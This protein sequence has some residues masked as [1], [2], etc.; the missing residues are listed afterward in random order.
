RWCRQWPMSAS[1]ATNSNPWSPTTSGR[2]R[3]IA[4]CCSSSK[5]GVLPDEPEAQTRE[6]RRRFG[7]R[8]VIHMKPKALLSWSSG[9]ARAWTL[10]VL[11]QRNEVEIVGLVTT[12]NEAA[13]RV[14]M[15]AVRRELVEAQARA[16]GAPLWPVMLPW[17]CSNAEYE[18]RM[19]QVI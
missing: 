2:S 11:R 13:N 17:P 6:S 14:A 9:K 1:T 3:P 5:C 18:V 16:A 15:H 4:R 10:Q 8:Y 12:F 7:L 19:R